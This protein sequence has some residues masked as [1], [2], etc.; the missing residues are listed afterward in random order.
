MLCLAFLLA[1]VAH[2]KTPRFY[3]RMM[4]F[5]PP[6]WAWLHLLAGV[7]E[8]LGAIGLVV[9]PLKKQAAWGLILLLVM[10]FPANVYVALRPSLFP[11]AGGITWVLRLPLQGVLIW[12]VWLYC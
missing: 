1:G 12:W 9:G 3:E 6:S 4:G 11:E 10:V 2:F 7:C 5:L 8:I